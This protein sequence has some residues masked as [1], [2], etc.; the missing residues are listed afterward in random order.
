MAGHG[1]RIQHENV[2]RKWAR[3]FAVDLQRPFPALPRMRRVS[4]PDAISACPRVA[5]L[6]NLAGHQQTL[7]NA[8]RPAYIPIM[9]LSKFSYY[10]DL[11]ISGLLIALLVGIEARSGTG[12]QW[13]EWM[14]WSFVGFFAWTLLEYV[15]HR[16]VYHAVPFFRDLHNAHHSEPAAYIG[17]PPGVT[18]L[19]ICL[20]FFAPWM[21]ASFLVASGLTAGMLIGYMAYMLVH[22]SAHFRRLAATSWFSATRRHHALHHHHS[23]SCN[24]GVTTR[25]WDHIF[26]TAFKGREQAD[27]PGIAR[28]QTRDFRSP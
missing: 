21:T 11:V 10:V 5:A 13:A 7:Y 15:V 23:V 20:L 28:R 4:L 18:I 6:S 12:I 9:Y 19:L 25:V 24:F 22:H 1:D 3:G 8:Q 17:A 16:W 26:G 27:P 2:L 14:F